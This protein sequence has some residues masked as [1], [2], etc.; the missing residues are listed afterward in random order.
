[1]TRGSNTQTRTFNYNSGTTV[2]GF[3]QSA[4]NPENGTVSYTYNTATGTNTLAS[5][6]DA[7]N[8][9]FTYQYDTYNRLG[10]VSLAVPYTCPPPPQSCNPPPPQVL[11]TYYYDTNPLDSTKKFSQN[12]LGR[13]TAVQYPAIGT[14]NTVQ[15]NDMYS[16]TQAGLPATKRLQVNEPVTYLDQNNSATTPPLRPTWTP[17]LPTTARARWCR[18]AILRPGTPSG[19]LPEPATIILTTV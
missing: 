2:T 17:L 9:Q 5:K 15:L 10:S 3:L 7:L 1:M 19:L 4:T 13:L 6:T 12:P 14:S 8:N 16:Y 18:R 11:R